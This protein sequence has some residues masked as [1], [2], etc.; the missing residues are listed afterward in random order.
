MW[1]LQHI[2]GLPGDRQR[3][4]IG[5]LALLLVNVIQTSCTQ[6]LDDESY[7]WMYSQNLAWGY[8]DHPP[9][10]AWM[11][12]A[13]YSL[14]HNTFGLRLFAI[15][16]I[17]ACAGI[18]YRL[19]EPVDPLALIVIF[20]SI[21]LVHFG[22]IFAVPDVPL[23][24]FSAVFLWLFR[25]Y[26]RKPSWSIALALGVCM[27]AL[28]YSKYNGILL[29]GFCLLANLHLARDTKFVTAS[30]LAAVLYSPHLY[31]QYTHGFPSLQYD[32]SDRYAISS[33][34][35]TFTSDYLL[36]QLFLFGP[37]IGWMVFY[38]AARQR[39]GGDA[40]IR[41]LKWIFWGVIGIFLLSS[42]KGRVEPNWTCIILVPAI[43]LLH[44][45][46]AQSP[47]MRNIV[48][49]QFPFSLILILVIRT[50]MIWQIFGDKVAI[51]IEL[52]DNQ[53]WTSLIKQKARDFPVYFVNSY[54]LASKYIFYQHSPA[55][56]YNGI[57]YRNNQYDFWQLQNTWFQDSVL[58]VTIDRT[59]VS[60]DSVVSSQGKLY[61]GIFANPNVAQDSNFYRHLP[62][63]RK[64]VP[65]FRGM[66]I[67]YQQRPPVDAR[68]G[69]LH[70]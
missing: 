44:R 70:Q 7:Y 5:V 54:Q 19:Q 32:L 53:V 38:A 20:L 6:L 4:L 61:C 36:G 52:H 67:E 31:W 47:R 62:P 40:W 25:V 45:Y 28:L 21:G 69:N 15:V 17:T 18:L 13:G 42:F 37:L 23:V 30:I 1:G 11:I 48:Y 34:D 46:L 66:A 50:S 64:L 35:W 2:G 16:A 8:Y 43:L 56:C 12:R 57:T 24:L 39:T 9:M 14:F 65:F 68:P 49:R 26:L 63:P 22:G 55:T 33:Y 60:A 59:Q 41:T 29:V 58:V 27:A 3:F 10:V 51:N